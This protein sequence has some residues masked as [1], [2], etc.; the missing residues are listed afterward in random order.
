MIFPM[1]IPSPDVQF[2]QIGPLRVYF[3]AL[4]IL[5]GIVLATIWTG[6]RLTRRGGERGVVIDFTV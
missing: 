1:S 5:T 4:C 6:R 3:Y 2:L